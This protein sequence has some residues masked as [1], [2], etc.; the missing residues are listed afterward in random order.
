MPHVVCWWRGPGCAAGPASA[1]GRQPSLDTGGQFVWHAPRQSRPSHRPSLPPL[2]LAQT[3]HLPAANWAPEAVPPA[4]PSH[5]APM[6]A[7][8]YTTGCG[9]LGP[10]L[11]HDHPRVACAGRWSSRTP[12]AASTRP[13]PTPATKVRSQGAAGAVP[14][15]AHTVAAPA[16]AR[17]QLAAAPCRP[18]AHM[19]CPPHAAAWLRG[20]LLQGEWRGCSPRVWTGSAQSAA[21]PRWYAPWLLRLRAHP[22]LPLSTALQPWGSRHPGSRCG[23]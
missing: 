2:G 21:A 7:P 20:K 11:T 19:P 23:C 16:R 22:F 10:G 3:R 14:S 12:F 18:T 4:S 17:G 15:P 5:P 9:L 13:T 1:P 6:P 8:P